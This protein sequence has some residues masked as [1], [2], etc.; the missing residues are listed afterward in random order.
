MVN[1][2]WGLQ[3]CM[4]AIVDYL[5]LHVRLNLE[6]CRETFH[7]GFKSIIIDLYICGGNSTRIR[8][9]NR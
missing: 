2:H 6:V 1:K 4:V 9:K 3:A 7:C 8:M 5:F